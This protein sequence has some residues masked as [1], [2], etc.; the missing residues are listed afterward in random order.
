[1]AERAERKGLIGMR[2]VES[3]VVGIHGIGLV[4]AIIIVNHILSVFVT[5]RPCE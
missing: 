1:M 3:L 5:V 4:F 2:E